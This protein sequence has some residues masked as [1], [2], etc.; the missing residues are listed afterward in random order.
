MSGGLLSCLD[1]VGEPLQD[2]GKDRLLTCLAAGL[3]LYR[4][5]D[6]LHN[7]ENSLVKTAC[8]VIIVT[9]NRGCSLYGAVR[10]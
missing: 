10:Y 7:E 2:E 6:L 3:G 5:G 9:I 1:L 4:P 8:I